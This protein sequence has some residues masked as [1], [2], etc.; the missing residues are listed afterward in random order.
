MIATMQ[1]ALVNSGPRTAAEV[2]RQL[3]DLAK[4]RDTAR[5]YGARLCERGRAGSH[6]QT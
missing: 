2:G 6:P 5:A 1:A 4:L 3:A